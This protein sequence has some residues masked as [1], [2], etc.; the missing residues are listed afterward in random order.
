MCLI[1]RDAPS[2]TVHVL[3]WCVH[4]AFNTLSL[5]QFSLYVYSVWKDVFDWWHCN[6]HNTLMSRLWIYL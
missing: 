1:L 5:T 6:A 4:I 3:R 2:V